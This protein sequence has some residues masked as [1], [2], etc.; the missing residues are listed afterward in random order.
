MLRQGVVRFTRFGVRQTPVLRARRTVPVSVAASRLLTP[1]QPRPF[2]HFR[3]HLRQQNT[4][5]EPPT[6]EQVIERDEYE[7]EIYTKLEDSLSPKFLDVRDISGGC[8]SM[9][10]ISIV[11]EKFNGVPMV[12]QHRIV[13]DVLKEDIKNWHGVQLRTKAAD[14]D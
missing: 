8:G 10:A 14:K 11:S 1:N 9:F 5:D 7:Q 4:N 2:S 12:K 13:N 6:A 3:G